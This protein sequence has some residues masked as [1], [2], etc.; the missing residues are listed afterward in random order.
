M[1]TE[2]AN[3]Y[4]QDGQSRRIHTLF[5]A[6]SFNTV[7]KIN[8]ELVR[9][10]ANLMSDGRPIL[11]LSL[12]QLCELVWGIDEQVVAVPA[13]IWTPWFSVFGSK[14]GFNSIEEC[15]GQHA[16]KIQA[17]ETGLSSDVLMNWKI[18]DL[19]NL[20]IISNSDSHSPGKMGREATVLELPEN[21]EFS[22][23]AKFKVA[24]TIEFHPEEG[25][26][27]YTGHRVCNVVQSPEETRQKGTTCHVCGRP[28]TVGVEH[29]VDE[30]A[31]KERL[32]MKA[33]E[34]VNNHGVKGYFHPTEKSR[35][36]YV[37][38]VPLMEIL[39]EALGTGSASKKV[40][41]L[42]EKMITALGPELNILLKVK[43]EEIVKAAGE[44]VGEG[45]KK[46]RRGEIVI[47]PGY[48]GVFGVVKIWPLP[49][50]AA[51]GQALKSEQE[52]LF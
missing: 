32:E 24:Y 8:A 45:I 36:P 34:K 35:P 10:G 30:L 2:I 1:G 37:M 15:F 5:F 23:V 39:G 7:H 22:D 40:E 47:Q 43:P 38:L 11:G 28:L 9:R 4:T 14:S 17:I 48:D 3:I 29:R 12:K 18:K 52:S 49:A 13:H 16:D 27:H 26:Y 33:I 20:A 25:K 44:K 41:E 31:D 21:Y 42:Y 51:A 6:P 46:V 19:D 50:T